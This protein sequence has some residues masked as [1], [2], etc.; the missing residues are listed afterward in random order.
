MVQCT[1]RI[2]ANRFGK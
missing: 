2:I 1:M